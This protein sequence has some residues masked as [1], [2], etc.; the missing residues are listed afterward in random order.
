MI[1]LK[2]ITS[3]FTL[4]LFATTGVFAQ[5]EQQQQ[6]AVSDDDLQ[7]FASAFMQVQAVDHQAQA[8]MIEAVEENGFSVERFNEI[9]QSL[10]SPE[11]E[12]DLSQ[13]E[14]ENFDNANSSIETIQMGAQQEMATKIEEEGLTINRYQEIMMAVQNDMEL[15]E[16]LQEYLQ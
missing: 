5:F 3:L 1:L 14:A 16:K 9:H 15:Q 11:L 7:L 4:L 8:E 10:Q 12:I 6:P 2:K 13:E